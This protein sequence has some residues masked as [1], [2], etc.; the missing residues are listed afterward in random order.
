MLN[1]FQGTLP[2][3]LVWENTENV[4]VVLLLEGFSLARE[5]RKSRAGG[6]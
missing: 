5:S 4:V 6:G 1:V 2:G 3:A